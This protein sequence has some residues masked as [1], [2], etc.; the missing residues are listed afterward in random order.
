M[1][2]DKFIYALGIRH[3]GEHMAGVLAHRFPSLQ[4]IQQADAQTLRQVPE[5]GPQVAESIVTFFEQKE[6]QQALRHLLKQ[7]LDIESP[8]APKQKQPLRGKTF[9]FTG[10]L[11]NYTRK[12]AQDIVERLG[13]R[14]ASS[15]SGNTDYVVVGSDPGSKLDEAEKNKVKKINEKEFQKMLQK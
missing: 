1:P 15:V 10:Q 3:V 5:I 6:N 4:K 8:P 9:V 12:E 14:A 11:E 7:G 13:A 2:L